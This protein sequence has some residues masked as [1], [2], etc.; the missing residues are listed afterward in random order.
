[1]CA[2]LP[3]SRSWATCG[4]AKW[5]TPRAGLGHFLSLPAGD[6]PYHMESLSKVT[7]IILTESS[8]FTALS[9]H[10]W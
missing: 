10:S 3:E 2:E 8:I 5:A 4:E 1:M 6:L 9:F 7:P